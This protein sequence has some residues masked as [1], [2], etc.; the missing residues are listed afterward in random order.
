M[1]AVSQA[2]LVI[3]RGVSLKVKLSNNLLVAVLQAMLAVCRGVKMENHIS[4]INIQTFRGIRNL[5]LKNVNQINILTGD[6]NSGKTSIL[7]V[8]QSY[9][10]PADIREWRSLLRRNTQGRMTSDITYY[11]GFYDLFNINDDEKKVEYSI[12]L[13]SGENHN[14]S[15]SAKESLEEILEKDYEKIRGFSIAEGDGQQDDN[16][17]TVAKMEISISLDGKEV[18]EHDIYD[19]Q[20]MLPYKNDEACA[21]Y[22]YD[23]RIIYISPVRHAEGN[24]YLRKVLDYPELYEQML[25]VLREYDDD[26]ISINYDVDENRYGR[27]SY[28]ILSKAN[29]KALPLN[30]YGDGM[31][32]AVLLMSAVI[33]AKDG[34]LL[35]DEF[36][37]AIHT[38][39]MTR[40]FKWIL[41]TCIKL[42]VQVFLTS[43]SREAIDKLLKC[44]QDSLD[45]ISVY[46]LYKDDEGMSVRQLSGRKAIEAQ[47]E[48]GLE[49]R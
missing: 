25:Q 21:A 7:E 19:G 46:T 38:S 10:N 5:E 31:K 45:K 4:D 42:N 23:G 37:T 49:L 33:A 32:K 6:N 44:S 36:E 22:A 13:D 41:E 16:V 11:E 35:L 34:I 17:R 28:K 27:G 9:Q 24:V 39:A 26:I 43:H 48:M 40:T 15:M 3:C 47:D 1:L 20:V 30:V 12:L 29:R 14:V 18:R 8:I 2:A